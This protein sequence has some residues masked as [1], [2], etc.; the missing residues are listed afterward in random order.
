MMP[1]TNNAYKHNARILRNLKENL[2]QAVAT[3]LKASHFQL[4][5]CQSIGLCYFIKTFV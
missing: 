4:S 2:L 3:I 1:K 5:D